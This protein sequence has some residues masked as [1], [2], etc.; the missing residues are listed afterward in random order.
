MDANKLNLLLS[1]KIFDLLNK[2][3]VEYNESSDKIYGCCPIHDGA[4][5][6]RAFCIYYS[7]G[8]PNWKCWTNFC[9]KKYK[10]S[11]LGL[12]R[13]LLSR[14]QNI[15]YPWGKTLKFIQ[16]FLGNHEKISNDYIDETRPTRQFNKFINKMTTEKTVTQLT[17]K[18][19]RDRLQ[20]PAEYYISRGFKPEV[21]ERFDV[22]FC[23]NLR[24]KFYNRVVI[25]VYN[26]QELYVGATARSI[27]D[28]CQ[29][30]KGF[31]Q[32]GNCFKFPKWLHDLNSGENLYN[33]YNAY[34]YIKQT[35]TVIL[36]ESPGNL[37]KLVQV[38]FENVVALFGCNLSDFQTILLEQLPIHNVVLLMD[39]DNAGQKAAATIHRKLERLFNF[40]NIIPT[41]NDVGEMTETEIIHLLTKNGVKPCNS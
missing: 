3:N 40:N 39:N 7:S 25:P 26:E 37:L 16:D 8:V 30:C 1:E 4:D 23:N 34:D 20:I 2:F 24:A 29:Q 35:K 11:L 21:L 36:V 38:G 12:V 22:G 13:G 17:R 6:P 28:Q 15:I 9:E 10:A 41:K 31:H 14:G 32:I 18:E 27:F 5:N 19:V 33:Y